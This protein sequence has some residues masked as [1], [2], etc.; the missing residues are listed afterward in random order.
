MDDSLLEELLNRHADAI[1]EGR[2]ISNQLLADLPG[3]LSEI[4]NLFRLAS[5]LKEI[6]V[7]K[8]V[9]VFRQKLRKALEYQ[10]PAEI[11]LTPPAPVVKKVL[12]GLAAT[13]SILSIAGL[14]FIIFRR[15]RGETQTAVSSA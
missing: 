7:P 11:T 13:G 5:T 15:R 9:P 3:N 6:L 8:T 12:M 1:V 2:D 4:D 14:S 10:A